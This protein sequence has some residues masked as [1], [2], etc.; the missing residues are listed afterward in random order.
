MSALQRDAKGATA[1]W[2]VQPA[3]QALRMTPVRVGPLGWN[4]CRCCPA[5]VRRTGVVAGGHLLREGRSSHRS[6]AKPS[7]RRRREGPL[8]HALQSFR[9]GVAQSH[10]RRLRDARARLVGV[11]SYRNCKLGYP[12][13]TFK[14]MVVRTVWP[15]I[16]RQSRARCYRAHREEPDDDGQVR[17]HPVVLAARR[18]AGDLHGARF[19]ARR[20]DPRAVVPGAQEDRRHQAPLPEG[21]IGPFFNDE[22][23]DTFGNIYA[24]TG[25]GFDYAVLKDYA[26][27]VE[28]ELQRAQDVGKV[29]LIGLQD[30]K[31]WIE[32]STTKLATLG[33][34]L[35]AV[36]QALSE[37][38][39]VVPSGSSKPIPTA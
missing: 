25:K 2:V 15:G 11:R 18:I 23:G 35:N 29:D 27:R 7:R 26:E 14:A 37:Q 19:A 34:P 17:V 6:I 10:A 3:T 12:P 22:F 16:G 30:E 28:L 31:V 9:M 4:R 36:Q 24:L 13:F 39:A 21:T 20:R 38:N 8:D 5:C 32:L 33:I 1:V